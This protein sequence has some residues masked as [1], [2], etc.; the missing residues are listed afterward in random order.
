MSAS[1]PTVD[2]P[3][4]RFAADLVAAEFPDLPDERAATTVAFIADRC[5]R[6]P[7]H[8]G[9]GV[10][11]IAAAAD[12]A[13]RLLGRERTHLFLCR[14]RL[15]IVADLARLVRSLAVAIIWERWPDTAPL[16]GMGRAV[17]T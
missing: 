2:G 13:S 15:P 4:G 16:G 7:Q 17:S 11:G 3:L 8:L 5:G 9:L 6:L 10:R 1:A 14:T 12:L